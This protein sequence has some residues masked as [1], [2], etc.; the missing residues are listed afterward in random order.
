MADLTKAVDR[1]ALEAVTGGNPGIFRAPTTHNYCPK[2]SSPRF[3]VQR[4][5][6]RLELRI[7][8]TCHLEYYY[9]KY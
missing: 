9:R 6:G 8:D 1:D 5:Q 2:C 3:R 7:C 4:I